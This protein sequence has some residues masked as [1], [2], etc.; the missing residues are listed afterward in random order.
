MA[1]IGSV[2]IAQPTLICDLTN[3]YACIQQLQ[4]GLLLEEV[5]SCNIMLTH[6]ETSS[7]VTNFKCFMC[8]IAWGLITPQ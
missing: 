8:H 5:K 3:I 2:T 4:D 1:L 7:A 6:V